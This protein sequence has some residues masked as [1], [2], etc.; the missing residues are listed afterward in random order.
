M[1][2]LM[3]CLFLFALI[4]ALSSCSAINPQVR[5]T[6]GD[7]ASLIY[8]YFDMSESPNELGAVMLTQ[9][10]RAGI[11]YRQS[12]MKTFTNGLF[13]ME[14]IPPMD[15]HIPFFYSGGILH[16][17]GGRKEDIFKVKPS[18]M[19][20]VGSFKYRDPKKG[21]I[22]TSKKF[23]MNPVKSPSEKKVLKMLLKHVKDEKWKKRIKKRL[24]RLKGKRR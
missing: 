15:Y 2:K 10:E 8:G 14:N 11:A 1:N 20:F 4:A 3:K 24:G 17:F 5:T 6:S 18:S 16:S 9:G 21:G 19:V 22:F 7:D 23:E 13:F 12:A